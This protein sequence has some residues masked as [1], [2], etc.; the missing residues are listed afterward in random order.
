MRASHLAVGLCLLALSAAGA[1][2]ETIAI[3][4][5]MNQPI[6]EET[7]GRQWVE[8]YNYGA[9]PVSISNWQM[10]DEQNDLI[11][12]PDTTIPP[13]GFVIIVTGRHHSRTDDN[14]KECFEKEWL[15]GKA[16]PRVFGVIGRFTLGTT[17]Q[18]FLRT[19]GRK[20]V[21]TLSYRNDGTP[22]RATFFTGDNFNVKF[23]GNKANPFVNRRGQDGRYPNFLG[24]ES[25]D[26]SDDPHA[27][28]SDVSGLEELM[29]VLYKSKE[30]GGQAEPGFGSP[31]KGHYSGVKNP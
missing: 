21:W 31:L 6:G 2:A 13:G 18:I 3:T 10:G 19:A 7:D 30:N 5:F 4:E 29:G 15:G 12:L 8:L 9:A 11:T 16:D 25:N 27:F 23:F 14:V 20:L 1:A 24:Y 17:D 22:G 28:R 26:A